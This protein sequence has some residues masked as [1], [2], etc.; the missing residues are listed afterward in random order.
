MSIEQESNKTAGADLPSPNSV[1]PEQPEI[2]AGETSDTDQTDSSAV[3][4]EP[5]L[6]TLAAD[7]PNVS[8]H[9]IDAHNAKEQEIAHNN[10]LMKDKR[11]DTFDPNI[12]AVEE[13]GTPKMTA[14]GNF[15]KKRGRKAGQ[16]NSTLNTGSVQK[17]QETIDPQKA[18]K[19][20][21]RQAGNAAANTLITLGVVM[22]GEE[23]QPIKN[24]E[25]GIDEKFTLEMAFSDYFE[26]KQMEDIPAGI[27]LS[28][29]IIGYA[30]PRF[31]MP[32]T[33]ERSKSLWGKVKKWWINRKLKKHGLKAEEVKKDT[34]KQENKKD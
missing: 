13:D 17:P 32:K 34:E 12:H 26:A 5:L 30:A 31:T 16:T 25:H 24:E 8:E 10:S 21:Q 18:L 4:F 11:G 14:A 1:Q 22:G 27:A 15:S 6:S 2:N 7:M 20:K 33:Q 29:A 9:V 28:I 3:G 19:N 23:W